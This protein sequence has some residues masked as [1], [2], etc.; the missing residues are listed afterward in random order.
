V[1]SSRRLIFGIYPGGV[2]GDDSGL[3]VGPPDEPDQ[4]NRCLRDLQGISQ[5]FVVRCYDSFQDSDSPLGNTG[6][7]PANYAQYAVS[8]VRPLELVLQFRSTS[9][10]VAGYLDFV[11]GKLKQHHQNLYAVQITE[12]PNFLDGPNVIDGPY[13]NVRL[14]LTEGVTAAKQTL[15]ELGQPHVKVGFNATP[16][17]GPSSEFWTD[18]K[19]LAKTAFVESLDYVG[20]DF[21]PD[22]FRPAA[23]DGQPG[24]LVS[25][26]IAVLE[27]LRYVWLPSA[28]IPD[29]IPIHI[30]EHGWPTSPTRSV[31]HQAQVLET[32]IRTIH[33]LSPKLNIER[34]MLFALRDVD[35]SNATNEENIF[36]FFGITTSDY[37]QKKPAFDKFRALVHELGMQ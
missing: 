28:G 1:T 5:P 36:R 6:P 15:R 26:V 23:S 19:S 10:D 32:V 25:S 3:L 13:P 34:Y 29:R 35:H 20:L 21:F 22:V 12:E 18:L 11:H 14:A 7:A 30:T 17:F 8:D 24:D 27:T 37:T 16:T 31:A 9:G 33:D 2:A 4:I